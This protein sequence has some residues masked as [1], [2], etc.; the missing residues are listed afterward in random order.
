MGNLEEQVKLGWA[1]NICNN[2]TYLELEDALLLLEGATTFVDGTDDLDRLVEASCSVLCLS[3]LGGSTAG[4]VPS[5]LLIVDISYQSSS[6]MTEKACI[7]D[8]VYARI[9]FCI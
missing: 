3:L 5:D 6:E 2:H 8:R 1:K 7:N 9:L 4:L